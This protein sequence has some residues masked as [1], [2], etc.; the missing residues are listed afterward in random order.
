MRAAQSE[1]P[2]HFVLVDLGSDDAEKALPR[3]L[4]AAEPQVVVRDGTVTAARL[5]RAVGTAD[6]PKW[7]LDG[8]VLITGAGG[9]LGGLVARH[10]VTRHGVRDLVLV[11]RGGPAPELVDELAALGAGWSPPAATRRTVRRW[12]S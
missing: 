1:H 5:V 8:T 6:E 7:D 3:A 4:T 9:V 10:L 12:P 11:G 2:G